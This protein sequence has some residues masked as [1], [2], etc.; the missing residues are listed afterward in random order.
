MI[1]TNRN[2]NF[3]PPMAKFISATSMVAVYYRFRRGPV[4]VLMWGKIIKHF[5]VNSMSFYHN[6]LF[7]IIAGLRDKYLSLMK[8]TRYIKVKSTNGNRLTE[9]MCNSNPYNLC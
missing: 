3:K 8:K 5:I 2:K 6:D 4:A 9:Y 7:L 1:C